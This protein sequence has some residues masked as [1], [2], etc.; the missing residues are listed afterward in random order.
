MNG[1][2]GIV[3]TVDLATNNNNGYAYPVMPMMG[4]YGYGNGFGGFGG[5]AIWIILLIA[6]FG[7]WGNNGNGGFFGGNNFVLR[8]QPGE[9]IGGYIRGNRF[10]HRFF[11]LTVCVQN[12]FHDFLIVI[13]GKIA[14][15]LGNFHRRVSFRFP[16]VPCCCS[17]KLSPDC[18]PDEANMQAVPPSVRHP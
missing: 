15:A 11:R 9:D 16:S 14:I 13:H 4:G 10:V 7:G 17:E 12:A 6:L 3:P 1:N 2:S 18:L 8:I 5:D